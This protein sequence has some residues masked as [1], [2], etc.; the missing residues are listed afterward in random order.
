M[1]FSTRGKISNRLKRDFMMGRS[2]HES[3]FTVHTRSHLWTET[4]GTFRVYLCG[5]RMLR[6]DHIEN[7]AEAELLPRASQIPAHFGLSA[8]PHL[9][10]PAQLRIR[11]QKARAGG[12]FAEP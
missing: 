7:A 3:S 5:I 12:S 1:D 6:C 9:G 10:R 11:S 2:W 4:K 8:L